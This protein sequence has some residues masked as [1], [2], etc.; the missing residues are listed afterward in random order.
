MAAEIAAGELLEKDGTGF[1]SDS[2][3]CMAK[4]KFKLTEAERTELQKTLPSLSKGRDHNF[5]D[6]HPRGVDL[7][8]GY[9]F[10]PI[11]Y[12]PR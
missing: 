2:L 5:V 4:R 6:N 3:G 7:V 10:P 1:A 9:K 8:C 11:R 12:I